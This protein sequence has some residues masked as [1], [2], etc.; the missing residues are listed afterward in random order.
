L[1]LN[2]TNATHKKRNFQRKAPS[3]PIIKPPKDTGIL[4]QLLQEET[5][6]ERILQDAKTLEEVLDD[7]PSPEDHLAEAERL[8]KKMERDLEEYL[9]G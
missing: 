6:L 1:A 9:H 7:I 8:V 2:P 3:K 4:E 5:S